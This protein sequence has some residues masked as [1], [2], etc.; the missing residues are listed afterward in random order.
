MTKNATVQKWGN[1]LA[2]RIPVDLARSAWLVVGQPVELSAQDGGLLMVPVGEPELSLSQCWR[3]LIPI[4]MAAKLWQRTL[5]G[6]RSI[7]EQ[8]KVY[9]SGSKLSKIRHKFLS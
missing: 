3:P 9:F 1:S 8:K 6:V 4:F 7:L 5:L 2:V